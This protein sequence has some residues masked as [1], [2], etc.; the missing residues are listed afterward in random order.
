MTASVAI[1]GLIPVLISTGIG[2]ET[3]RPWPRW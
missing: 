1:L 2:A 3:Q